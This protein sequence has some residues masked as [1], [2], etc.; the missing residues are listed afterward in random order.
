[1]AA[2]AHEVNVEGVHVQ[3]HLAHRLGGVGVEEYLVLAAHVP[4]L[5]QRLDDANLVVD[6]HDADEDGVRPDGG[7]QQLQVHQAVGL[8]W[9]VGDI[10]PLLLHVPAAVQHALVVRLRGD[11]VT[12]LVLVEV[13]H[14]LDGHVV[15]LSRPLCA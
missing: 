5:S 7:L 11:D 13:G 9:Q 12:L 6:G 15:A 2:D 3:G 8:H 4:N 10:P 1:V 14:A